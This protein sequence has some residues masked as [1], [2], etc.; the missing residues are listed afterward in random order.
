MLSLLRLICPFAARI[1][2]R[3]ILSFANGMSGVAELIPADLVAAASNLGPLGTDLGLYHSSSGIDSVS[4]LLNSCLID[5]SFSSSFGTVEVTG[6]LLML[7]VARGSDI[8]FGIDDCG[9]SA[10]M[11]QV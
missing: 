1:P 8:D 5:V 9:T 6:L 4:S 11:G 3:A 10:A 7:D 2:P